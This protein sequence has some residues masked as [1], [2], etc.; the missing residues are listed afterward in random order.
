M[1]RLPYQFPS[2]G[3]VAACLIVNVWP[4]GVHDAAISL[5]VAMYEQESQND[6]CIIIAQFS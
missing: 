2:K 1:V 4:A 3:A 5:L 6:L